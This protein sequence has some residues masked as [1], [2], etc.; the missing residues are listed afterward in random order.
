LA[1]EKN[2]RFD[3]KTVTHDMYVQIFNDSVMEYKSII[4]TD[5]PDLSEFN[6]RGGKLLSFHGLVALAIFGYV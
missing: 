3:L 1:V 4:G 5:D 2:A 6:K